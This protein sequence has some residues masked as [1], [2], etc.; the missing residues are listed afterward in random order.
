M[1]SGIKQGKRG[2]PQKKIDVTPKPLEVKTKDVVIDAK[3]VSVI[4][5]LAPVK[6]GRGRPPK[7]GVVKGEMNITIK[8]QPKEDV[9]VVD[10]YVQPTILRK[11]RVFR[12]D[13]RLFHQFAQKYNGDIVIMSYVHDRM[14]QMFTNGKITIPTIND[15]Y[16]HEWCRMTPPLEPLMEKEISSDNAFMRGIPVQYKYP[17]LIDEDMF[18]RFEKSCKKYPQYISNEL[19]KKMLN[20]DIKIDI[21]KYKEWCTV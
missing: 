12:F 17:L 18:W 21:S 3:P 5:T 9:V 19:L 10:D 15:T 2:R 13:K 20:E 1:K 11:K 6:R 14:M 16:Y 8:S 7:S 4:S